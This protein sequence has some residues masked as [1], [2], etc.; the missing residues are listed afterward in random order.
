MNWFKAYWFK[1][2]W[3]GSNWV[4][5]LPGSSLGGLPWLRRRRR[6]PVPV[7]REAPRTIAPMCSIGRNSDTAIGAASG[8]TLG[9][10][11]LTG[12]STVAV[13]RAGGTLLTS[14]IGGVSGAKTGGTGGGTPSTK[15]KLPQ[16][17]Q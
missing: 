2:R 17:T 13:G 4:G 8:S 12:G 3:F 15:P 6:W 1:A 11:L 5:G 7:A 10:S 14:P 9:G 16:F